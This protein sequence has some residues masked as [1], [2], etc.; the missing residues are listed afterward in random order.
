MSSRRYLLV[1]RKAPHARSHAREALDV[2]MMA[3]AFEHEVSI[4][5]ID[6]GVY[7]L[8]E[9]Q[10]TSAT[11]CHDFS[12]LFQALE[13]YGI[14]KVYVDSEA[15]HQRGIDP[16]RLLIPA[17]PLANQALAELIAQHELLLSF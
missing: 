11:G 17:Q 6:D 9:G 1:T 10:D 14:E 16:Q 13:L 12:P 5:F 8:L 4:A 2:A 3:A 7:Q 15:L